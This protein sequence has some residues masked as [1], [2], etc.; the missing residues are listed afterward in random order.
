[1][2]LRDEIIKR[3]L[4]KIIEKSNNKLDIN[5]IVT[6]SGTSS[7]VYKKMV[8]RITDLGDNAG[9]GIMNGKV[10]EINE[11]DNPDSVVSMDKKTFSAIILKKVDHRQAY[12][13]GAIEIDGKNWVRDAI[14]IGKV[15]DK[16]SEIL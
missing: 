2:G 1:M 15:F 16:M 11:I 14:V 8:I 10:V 4:K 6:E 9:L 5:T 3:V 13:M 12:W 7:D